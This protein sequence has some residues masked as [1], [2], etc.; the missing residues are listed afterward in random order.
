[1]KSFVAT[2]NFDTKLWSVVITASDFSVFFCYETVD[3]L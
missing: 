3:K 2:S 1:M